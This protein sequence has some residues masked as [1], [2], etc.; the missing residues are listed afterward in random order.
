L[1][2][3]FTIAVPMHRPFL[4]F[5]SHGMET[6]EVAVGNQLPLEVLLDYAAEKMDEVVLRA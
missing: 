2:G 4:C 5:S 1:H 3:N 6:K